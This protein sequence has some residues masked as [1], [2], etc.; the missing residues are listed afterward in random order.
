MRLDNSVTVG[1]N[2][3]SALKSAF[4]SL[5]GAPNFYGLMISAEKDLRDSHTAENGGSSEMGVVK[6]ARF[7]K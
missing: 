2:V 5:F 6:Q 3:G 4:P 7:G 1:Q